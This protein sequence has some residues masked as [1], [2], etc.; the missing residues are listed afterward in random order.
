M[1][2]YIESRDRSETAEETAFK[3]KVAAEINDAYAYSMISREVSQGLRDSVPPDYRDWQYRT[4]GYHTIGKLATIEE[5]PSLSTPF[6]NIAE[7]VSRFSRDVLIPE[8]SSDSPIPDKKLDLLR[9][10][11]EDLDIT[12]PPSAMSRCDSFSESQSSSAIQ[13]RD[14]S[15][16]ERYRDESFHFN[17]AALYGVEVLSNFRTNRL[18]CQIHAILRPKKDRGEINVWRFLSLSQSVILLDVR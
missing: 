17:D 16:N 8:H 13:Q 18:C 6:P 4:P 10:R 14:V 9:P 15:N 2:T 1:T 7:Q 12:V 5:V 3:R 11:V